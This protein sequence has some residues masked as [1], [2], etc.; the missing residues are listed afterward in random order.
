MEPFSDKL[1]PNTP[2]RT[3]ILCSIAIQILRD[4]HFLQCGDLHDTLAIWEWTGT[5][6]FIHN[7]VDDVGLVIVLHRVN[8]LI[9]YSFDADNNKLSLPGIQNSQI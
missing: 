5:G 8:S 3:K 9:I 4:E 7:S 1:N 6:Q 2:Y